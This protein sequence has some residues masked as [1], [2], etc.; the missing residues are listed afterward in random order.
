MTKT[1]TNRFR[2]IK[3]YHTTMRILISFGWIYLLA[4]F[5]G[6]DWQANKLNSAYIR[7][8]KRLKNTIL[9]YMKEQAKK[10]KTD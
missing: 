8:A 9:P 5:F 3:A 6:S 2:L 7:N 1:K 4:Y 10:I